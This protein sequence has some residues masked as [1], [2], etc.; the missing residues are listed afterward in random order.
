M[1]RPRSVI[2]Q[3]ELCPVPEHV[4]GQLYRASSHQLDD[5]VASVPS[6]TR[7]MLAL[8]CYRRTHLQD[9]GLAIATSCS[10]F[11]LREVGGYAGTV[12]FK[13]AREAPC[14]V[15]R[16]HFRERL[17]VTLSTGILKDVVKDDDEELA[18]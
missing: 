2:P 17:K 5:V 12:L 15:R 11:D 3:E 9:I 4:L 13:K 10:E 8:Y 6:S 7:A 14:H 16:T 1:L 18:A